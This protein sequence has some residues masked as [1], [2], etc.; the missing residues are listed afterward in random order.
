[1]TVSL[2]AP[3]AKT[4]QIDPDKIARRIS[5]S[6]S[7]LPSRDQMR[8]CVLVALRVAQH[9]TFTRGW[10]APPATDTCVISIIW[11]VNGRC[12]MQ[13]E[14]RRLSFG[15]GYAAVCHPTI[16]HQLWAADDS[17][18]IAGFAIEGALAYQLVCES[19][20]RAGVF[21]CASPPVDQIHD[22]IQS[23]NDTSLCGR[24]TASLLAVSAVYDLAAA[25]RGDKTPAV[26][27]QAKEIIQQEFANPG[28]TCQAVA[29]KVGRNRTAFSRTFQQYTGAT[30]M[31]YLTQV[32][33]GQAQS[34]IRHSDHKVA[35]IGRMCGFH[36][37]SYFARW[38]RKH[39]GYRPGE[40]RRRARL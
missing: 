15:P 3:P 10:I 2:Q 37:P 20:L 17:T 27:H 5:G 7:E 12:T 38:L 13:A 28:L 14:S 32:R 31:D 21:P 36:R 40:L 11:V 39:T 26:V 1:M 4:T 29:A 25:T 33:L 23:L 34:L 6:Y 35:E 18:E 19:G 16:G 22:L 24:Q 9:V 8:H 30:V